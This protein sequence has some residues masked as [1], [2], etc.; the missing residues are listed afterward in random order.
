MLRFK[1]N[2]TV[3]LYCYMYNLNSILLR[4]VNLLLHFVD[5][6]VIAVFMVD[7]SV[8]FL[9]LTCYKCLNRIIHLGIDVLTAQTSNQ[10]H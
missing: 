2:S 5:A 9:L 7:V 10:A 8:S 4:L 1:L 6:T 3:I